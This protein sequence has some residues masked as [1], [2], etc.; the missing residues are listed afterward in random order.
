[1]TLKPQ[2]NSVS[3]QLHPALTHTCCPS[4]SF[5]HFTVDTFERGCR[6]ANANDICMCCSLHR[7][8][9][10]VGG[11]A[12]ASVPKRPQTGLPKRKSPSSLPSL[13]S[14]DDSDSDDSSESDHSSD[15]NDD[16]DD[17]DNDDFNT[18]NHLDV[19][20]DGKTPLMLA[21]HMGN[22]KAA[23]TL[24]AAGADPL[25]VC[26]STTLA[27]G[28]RMSQICWWNTP[29]HLLVTKQSPNVLK[30][31]VGVIKGR[32]ELQ[33]EFKEPCSILFERPSIQ[34]KHQATIWD[35]MGD[36]ALTMA[37]RLR[38]TAAPG[39]LL[40]AGFD[41]LQLVNFRAAGR[42]EDWEHA[43]LMAVEVGVVISLN[44]SW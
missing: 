11:K 3:L 1:M 30:M 4:S 13:T 21:I 17:D 18:Y 23:K 15:Q 19:M 8:R 16:D 42:V 27:S 7:A 37:V 31:V 34:N 24:L 20:V 36:T 32:P 43:L 22:M 38:Q 39:V 44:I 10:A 33:L 12:K 26:V 5:F 25:T 35:G 6:I 29:L 28:S 40:N 41:P 2:A 9:E 14:D